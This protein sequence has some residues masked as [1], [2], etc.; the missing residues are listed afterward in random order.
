MK[1]IVASFDNIIVIPSSSE[2]TSFGN[3][4][5]PD[6]GKE[7]SLRG[8]VISVGPGRRNINGDLI[9]MSISEGQEVLLPP[10]GAV[11]VSFQGEEYWVCSENLVLGVIV[12]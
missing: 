11:K 3:I 7:Q 10:M 1:K 6:L 4:I 2:E 12:K 9:P 5:V 8:T